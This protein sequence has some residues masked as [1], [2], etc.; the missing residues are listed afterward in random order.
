[1]LMYWYGVS[2][3]KAA[4]INSKKI[5]RLL[6]ELDV[7]SRAIILYLLEHKHAKLDELME[8]LDE[9]SHMNTLTRIQ[10]VINQ[11][12]L[13][14]LKRPI[15]IFEKS[16]IDMKTGENVLF[17]WWLAKEDEEKVPLKKRQFLVDVF[18]E[19]SEVII[20]ID[21]PGIREEDIKVNIEKK[22]VNISFRDSKRKKHV[23]EI[24]LP[25]QVN[26]YKFSKQ[27]KNQ[28]LTIRILKNEE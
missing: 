12:A 16:R 22:R 4:K 7:G 1:M 13:K 19:E 17:N 14:I 9:S 11:K 6:Q 5:D 3:M 10:N 24:F 21:L 25:S 18:D 27:F 23:E 8:I 28:I 2:I 20:T 15:L 26:P